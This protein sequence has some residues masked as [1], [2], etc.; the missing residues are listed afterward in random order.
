MITNSY[1]TATGITALTILTTLSLTG[2]TIGETPTSSNT[3]SPQPTTQQIIP[4]QSLGSALN[5]PMVSPSPVRSRQSVG[6]LIPATKG[7]ERLLVIEKGRTDPFGQILDSRTKISV[8]TLLPLTT[9]INQQAI[10]TNTTAKSSQPSPMAQKVTEKTLLASKPL[11]KPVPNLAVKSSQPSPMAQK[12]TE[13][14]LLASKPLTKPVP[15]LAVKSPQPRSMAPKATKKPIL[16]PAPQPKIAQAVVVTGIVLIGEV[17]QAIIKAPNESTSRYVKPG[18]RLMNG[19]LV[20]RIEMRQGSNP[21]VI[22]EQYGIEV[23][24]QVGEKP[25]EESQPV[26]KASVSNYIVVQKPQAN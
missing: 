19:V 5:N 26:T 14:T 10:N 13:K 25:V 18:Q 9:I 24:K 7:A 20:K 3:A 17:P 23:I 8:P 16:P 21:T 6:T 4:S 1:I 11:T 2:C 22:L 12:V 15:N